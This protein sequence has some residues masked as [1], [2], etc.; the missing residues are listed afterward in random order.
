MGRAMTLACNRKE[1]I[2]KITLGHYQVM[3]APVFPQSRQ[4]DPDL[5]PFPF[6]LRQAGALLDEAGWTFDPSTGVRTKEVDG[7]RK[8]FEFTLLYQTGAQETESLLN[9]YKNDLLSI[10]VV[11]KPAPLEFAEFVNRTHDRRFEA[12]MGAWATE[13]WDHDFDQV[14]H[15][16]QI[17]EPSSSNYYEFSNPELDALSDSL[18][19][20]MDI[21]KRIEKVRKIARILHEEQPC[22]FFG[23]A[24]AFGARYSWLKNSIEH[25]YKTRPFIRPLP[26]WVDK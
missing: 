11:M 4:A 18:R 26:M 20:E 6:D 25:T 12:A 13:P 10:G 14:W 3:S 16:R 23:W 24:V 17:Q 19:K 9:Y 5:Q 15:S 1:I 7:E 21:E 22:T 8:K 2:D